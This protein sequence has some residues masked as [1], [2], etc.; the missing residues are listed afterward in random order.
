MDPISFIQVLRKNSI[1]TLPPNYSA[2]DLT[3]TEILDQWYYNPISRLLHNKYSN[4]VIIQYNKMIK[5]HIKRCP[6]W[7]PFQNTQFIQCTF[8]KTH[9]IAKDIQTHCFENHT[10]EYCLNYTVPII[11]MKIKYLIHNS[12]FIK[13]IKQIENN[14]DLCEVIG[15]LKL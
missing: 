1:S 7:I 11:N 5:K 3:V 12:V 4:V 13:V 15:K 10:Q 6:I 14:P 8:C 9:V 2:Y